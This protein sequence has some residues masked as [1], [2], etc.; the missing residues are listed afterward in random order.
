MPRKHSV[1]VDT[2]NKGE[3]REHARKISPLRKVQSHGNLS[4]SRASP[5]PEFQEAPLGRHAAGHEGAWNFQTG[6]LAQR[7][8]RRPP[9]PEVGGSNPPSPAIDFVNYYD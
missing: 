5:E 2:E 4:S 1:A 3:P 7:I 6:R 8:E 9:K